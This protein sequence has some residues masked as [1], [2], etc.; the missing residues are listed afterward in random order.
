MRKSVVRV[1]LGTAGVLLIPF[2]GNRYVDG[3]NW[4]WHSF[5]LAGV[6][7][8][9]SG[10]AYEL[11]THK[12]KANKAYRF[13]VGLA[14]VTAFVLTWVNLAV[15]IIGEFDEDPV[16]LLFLAVPAVGVVGAALSRLKP[17]GMARALFATALAQVLV[18]VMALTTGWGFTGPMRPQGLLMATGFFVGL[19][20]VSGWLFQ[21][22]ARGPAEALDH[23]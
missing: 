13:A 11:V 21:R 10:L 12:K 7:V 6:L 14:V 8:F 20:L 22:A 1:A 23:G 4:H 5:V 17:R 15:G 2:F 16:N 18:A 9:S 19:W 3:W